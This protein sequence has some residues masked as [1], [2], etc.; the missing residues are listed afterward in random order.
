MLRAF[1]RRFLAPQARRRIRRPLPAAAF[2]PRLEALEDRVVPSTVTWVHPGDGDWS[3]GANWSTG[4][5]PGTND[6]VVIN[7]DLTVTHS[8]GSDS[9]RSLTV[10]KGA[11]ALTGGSVA[12]SSTATVDSALL[13]AGGTLN[14]LNKDLDGGG[15]T[16]V[17]SD[18]S[19]TILGGGLH[20][21]VIRTA[22]DNQGTL[23]VRGGVD[24]AGSFSNDSGRRCASSA[25]AP[26]W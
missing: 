25:T 23:E 17:T 24:V 6:D 14:L 1:V 3:V 2:R 19:W 7:L 13:I 10:S 20:K 21:S 4:A 15:T 18:G 16:T 22:L 12:F 11:L 5:T 26:G 9:V 8:S